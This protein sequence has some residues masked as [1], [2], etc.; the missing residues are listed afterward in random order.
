MWLTCHVIAGHELSL[1]EQL[2]RKEEY[3]EQLTRQIEQGKA[4]KK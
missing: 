3:R 1:S 2:R 4:K